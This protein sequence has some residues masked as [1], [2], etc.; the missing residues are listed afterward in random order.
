MISVELISSLKTHLVKSAGW[1]LG[2]RI[3]ISIVSF[4]LNILLVRL[5]TPSQLGTFF[6]T[7]SVVSVSA[8]IGQLGLN[9]TIV[10]VIARAMA[11]G[12][13]ECTRSAIRSIFL[14]ALISTI[15]VVSFLFFV[16]WKWLSIHIFKS[17]LML[18]ISVFA[19][20]WIVIIVFQK[21]IAETFRGFNDIRLASIFDDLFTKVLFVVVL[22]LLYVWKG[23]VNLNAVLMG[24]IG[25]G[26]IG[27]II[28]GSLLQRLLSSL[29]G[30]KG[31]IVVIRDIVNITLPLMLTDLMIY[32]TSQVDIWVLGAFRSQPEVAQ[33]GVVVRIVSLVGILLVA[34]NAVVAPIVAEMYASNKKREMEN[35]IRLMA[36][37]AGFPAM[38]V[39][40]GF[41]FLGGP[42]LNWAFGDF[43]ENGA[44]VLALLGIG[45]LATVLTGSCGI[46]LMMTGYQ[47][48]MM[49][50]T[51]F[52]GIFSTLISILL[53]ERFGVE[54]LAIGMA[55]SM[56]IMNL[57]MWYFAKMR[58]G[59]WT[60]IYIFPWEFVEKAKEFWSTAG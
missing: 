26:V 11:K 57:L 9:R 47:K 8:L 59:I 2:A 29:S 43:Y 44:V 5:L 46:T 17:T 16:L 6:L 58:V 40:L 21:L 53:V 52:N 32:I 1:A 51:M 15:F 24:Y 38:L 45:K 13:S 14:L 50:I 55:L 25:A 30:N 56:I 39:L 36:T 42:L 34:V 54:G 3:A 22:F 7:S 20:I 37:L 23:N 48:I 60:H 27:I 33:Y 12:L 49:K 10:Q 31:D 18:G 35:V 19:M 28:A 4:I 41:I